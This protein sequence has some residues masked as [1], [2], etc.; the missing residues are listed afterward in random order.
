MKIF[1]CFFCLT[2]F[3]YSCTSHS[4]KQNNAEVKNIDTLSKNPIDTDTS[5]N[6]RNFDTVTNSSNHNDNKVL[7]RLESIDSQEVTRLPFGCR[8]IVTYKFPKKWESEG[9]EPYSD[10][11][12]IN[13]EHNNSIEKIANCYYE[14]NN[15]NSYLLPYISQSEYIKMGEDDFPS[16]DSLMYLTKE[17]KYSLP[18]FGPYECYYS[19]NSGRYIQT[20]EHGQD[21]YNNEVGNLI[22]YDRLTKG[23]KYI[24]IYN[25]WHDGETWNAQRYF[26]INS[27]KIIE[28]FEVV[29]GETETE[30]YKSYT[31]VVK[32]NGEILIRKL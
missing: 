6:I 18:N 4:D 11:K 20:F 27:E 24:N 23:A 15:A 12:G 1:L 25:Q 9:E 5:S 3:I 26:F 21:L 13:K 22:F 17:C 29:Y 2:L 10:P 19:Y 14:L 32:D 7:Y 16:N 28:V 30:F 31:I 8:T